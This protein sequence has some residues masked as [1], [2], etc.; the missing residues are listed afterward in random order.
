MK[1]LTAELRKKLP[2]LGSTENKPATDVKVIAKYFSIAS[3]WKWYAVEFDGHDTF[4]GMVAGYENELG[5]FSLLELDTLYW[6]N[7]PAI[8]RDLYWTPMS[9]AELIS[10]L[11]AGERP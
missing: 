1:L 2:K 5:Y 3:G 4:Y 7:V 8:E 10:K 9:M 6:G 11:D